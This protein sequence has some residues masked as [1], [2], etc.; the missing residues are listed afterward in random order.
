MAVAAVDGEE[1]VYESAGS[2]FYTCDILADRIA[3][4]YQTGDGQDLLVQASMVSG[5]WTG[6][7]TFAEAD[8]EN[9]TYSASLPRDADEL[10]VSETAFSYEGAIQK[11][12]D[13][14][15][16]NAE[17]LQGTI[18][19]NC[20]SPGGDPVAVIDG[21]TYTFPFSGAQSSDCEVSDTDVAVRI[22]R[23]SR[24]D[25]QLAIDMRGGP[26]DWLG[27]VSISA[28]GEDFLV[29]LSGEAE[30]FDID[31]GTVTYAGPIENGAGDEVE[32]AVSV[33][34]P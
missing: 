16:Q 32:A 21:T 28:S 31:G 4:N 2:L 30:G 22:N 12:T 8:G 11:V 29:T 10:G 18:A 15:V 1:L 14:D 13:F 3:I 34:C 27:S 19:V 17:E 23:L 7:I 25:L 33:T 20:A 24:D 26:D 5:R 6:S 9:I